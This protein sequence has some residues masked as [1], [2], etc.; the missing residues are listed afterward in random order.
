MYKVVL[1]EP[2]QRQLRKLDRLTQTRLL[3]ALQKLESNPRLETNKRLKGMESLYR[4]RVGNY[5][6][7]YRIEDDKLLVL[8]VVIAHRR[9]VYKRL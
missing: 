9:E 6:I 1:E 4:M 7:L 5:R 2:A 8:I 3:R